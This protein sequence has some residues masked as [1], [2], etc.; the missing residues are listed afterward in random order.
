M[1]E[2]FEPVHVWLQEQNRGRKAT[3]PD[4]ESS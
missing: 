3:L 1:A 2:Y 4:L